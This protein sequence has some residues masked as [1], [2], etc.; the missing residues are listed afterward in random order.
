MHCRQT[1]NLIFKSHSR[2]PS[3]RFA[4]RLSVQKLVILRQRDPPHDNADARRFFLRSPTYIILIVLASLVWMLVEW[5]YPHGIT[6]IVTTSP[7]HRRVMISTP[8]S[9]ETTSSTEC[10]DTFLVR[11]RPPTPCIILDLD[12]VRAL[13]H[14][15]RQVLP[16]ADIYYAVKP[17]HQVARKSRYDSIRD[18]LA[19]QLPMESVLT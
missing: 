11:R 2:A 14:V 9:S 6:G 13:H 12:I 5:I 4:T 8:L 7:K 19:T 15:L 3:K 18:S 16:N 17:R 1:P 10:I